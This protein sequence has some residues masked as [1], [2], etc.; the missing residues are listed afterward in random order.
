[1][2]KK[3]QRRLEYRMLIQPTFDETLKKSGTLFFIE[4][5]RQFANFNY[6]VVV[7]DSLADKQLTWTLRGLRAPELLMP[8]FGGAQYR[9]TYFGLK[10]TYS[11]VLRKIDGEENEFHLRILPTSV[12]VHDY[13]HTPFASVYTNEESFEETREQE[14]EKPRNKPDIRRSFNP[15]SRKKDP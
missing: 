6:E 9:K 12:S 7:E 13:P 15:L 4:T 11:F 5:V 8:S 14:L 1:M 3:R 10:G 2:T